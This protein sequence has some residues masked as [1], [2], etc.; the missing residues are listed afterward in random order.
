[1]NGSAITNTQ[2]MEHLSTA[3]GLTFSLLLGHVV[4]GWLVSS[5]ASDRRNIGNLVQLCLPLFTFLASDAAMVYIHAWQEFQ[6]AAEALYAKS[7]TKVRPI[8]FKSL[9]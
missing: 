1:M 7:P 9:I 6:D 4:A 5:L 3:H 2:Y 8:L